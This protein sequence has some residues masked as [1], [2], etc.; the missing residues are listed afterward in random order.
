MEI[1]I[2]YDEEWA[3]C[4][5]DGRLA[6]VGDSYLAEEKAFE[7]LGVKQVSDDSFMRGQ[8]SRDGVAQTLQEVEEYRTRRTERERQASA[9]EVEASRLLREADALRRQ[10]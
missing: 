10:G 7:L 5:V 1:E 8:R 6:V 3:A 9:L 4:Y 2:H